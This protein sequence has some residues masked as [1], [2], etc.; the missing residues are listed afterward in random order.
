MGRP[1]KEGHAPVLR[2]KRQDSVRSRVIITAFSLGP[3]KK[4]SVFLLTS[5]KAPTG[6]RNNFFNQTGQKRPICFHHIRICPLTDLS[7]NDLFS[8]VWGSDG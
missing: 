6:A 8:V 1:A 3:K 4:S 7:A 5:R 2:F